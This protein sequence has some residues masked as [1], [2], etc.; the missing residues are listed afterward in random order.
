MYRNKITY[1]IVSF[2]LVL[3]LF[4]LQND[5]YYKINKSFDVFG[6]TYYKILENYVIDID[7]ELLMKKDRKSTR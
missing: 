1:M 7:P 4:S 2:C 3:N 6:D 5:D